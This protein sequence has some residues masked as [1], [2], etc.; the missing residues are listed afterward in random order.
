MTMKPKNE[1]VVLSAPDER[2][3]TEME[4]S[5]NRALATA[6]LSSV[7]EGLNMMLEAGVPRE[8]G[9]RVLDGTKRRRASD[10]K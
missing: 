6:K 7:P 10:W 1:V 5:V 9:I 3:N 4:L 2:K 8:V